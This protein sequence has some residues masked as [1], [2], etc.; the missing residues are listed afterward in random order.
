MIN[1]S[2]HW[3][4]ARCNMRIRPCCWLSNITRG[5]DKR[6]RK[7]REKKGRLEIWKR[8]CRGRKGEEEEEE[9][10]E[11]AQ[12]PFFII[13]SFARSPFSALFNVRSDPFL[14][15]LMYDLTLSYT[16]LPCEVTFF[17]TFYCVKW[18]SSA[19]F[20]SQNVYIIRFPPFIQL[21]KG[22]SLV[23][24]AP[25]VGIQAC[26]QRYSREESF[27]Y[28]RR[29]CLWLDVR[30]TNHLSGWDYAPG[31]ASV[32]PTPKCGLREEEAP[33]LPV[34]LQVVPFV[35]SP[36]GG[37]SFRERRRMLLYLYELVRKSRRMFL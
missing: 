12:W 28:N 4:T 32:V 13:F 3:A 26:D 19:P 22:F 11:E 15:F 1:I 30:G 7:R 24:T 21:Q 2:R 10:R 20:T 37:Y 5:R 23:K 25:S 31:D 18:P 9:G 33:H 16:F 27:D 29:V 36:N 14:H 34:L 35:A 6:K 17:C 8:N